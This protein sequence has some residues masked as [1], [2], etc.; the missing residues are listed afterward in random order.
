MPARETPR[1]RLTTPYEL[2]RNLIEYARQNKGHEDKNASQVLR[3][4]L[5]AT[6]HWLQTNSA[7][8]CLQSPEDTV[9][10]KE[11]YNG[12]MPVQY[13]GVRRLTSVDA[14]VNPGIIRDAPLPAAAVCVFALRH[15]VSGNAG[16]T[17]SE[18]AAYNAVAVTAQQ[19]IT[20]LDDDDYYKTL[21]S[22]DYYTGPVLAV[23]NTF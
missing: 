10:R 22:A 4:K 19:P 1:L 18:V 5:A 6:A 21:Q 7:L 17:N 14:E 8:Y 11:F 20:L 23:D 2:P 16:F 3:R 13:V 9:A 12:F 15:Y